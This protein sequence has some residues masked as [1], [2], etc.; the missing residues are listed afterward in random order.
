M[1][2]DVKAVVLKSASDM[3]SVTVK[4]PGKMNDGRKHDGDSNPKSD[5]SSSISLSLKFE[6][7]S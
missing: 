6:E 2:R 1:F 7:I 5:G 4:H 3:F